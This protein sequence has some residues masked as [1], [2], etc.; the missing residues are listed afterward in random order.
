[1]IH[2]WKTLWLVA[3]RYY[4]RITRTGEDTS[5]TPVRSNSCEVKLTHEFLLSRLQV[6]R[7]FEGSGGEVLTEVPD[8]ILLADPVWKS[9]MH[10]LNPEPLELLA[11]LVFGVIFLDFFGELGQRRAWDMAVVLRSDNAKGAGLVRQAELLNPVN[12]RM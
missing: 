3:A 4:V 6:F 9:V 1:M 11:V 10:Q 8:H 2:P 12:T 7:N 5:Q